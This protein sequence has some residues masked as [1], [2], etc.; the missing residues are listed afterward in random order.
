MSRQGIRPFALCCF[1]SLAFAG[2]IAYGQAGYGQMAAGAAPSF[3]MPG[4]YERVSGRDNPALRFFGG[5]RALATTPL[6]H[7]QQMPAPQ[8]VHTA[9]YTKP[10]SAPQAS[11]SV[12]PYL[13]LDQLETQN[14]LP[15]YYLF[16]KPQ[17]EQAATNQAQQLQNRRMQQQMRRAS[18]GGIIPRSTSGGMP[19][20][21]HSTQFMN[22]GGYFPGLQK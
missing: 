7:T 8:P 17:L 13:A 14:G 1:T 6:A 11:P 21:G 10:Y 12:S 19:T 16:V 20:T 4:S 2:S 5:S 9:A 18:M 22:S 15:N 3:R